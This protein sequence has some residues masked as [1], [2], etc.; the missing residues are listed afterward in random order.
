MD[1]TSH[2]DGPSDDRLN[3][4][5]EIAAYLR[6]SE[7]TVRRWQSEGLPVHRHTHKKRAGIYA[8][9]PELDAWWNGHARL[10]QMDEIRL[11]QRR[12]IQIWIGAGILAL[13]LLAGM[14]AARKHIE[15]RGNPPPGNARIMV[16]VLPFENLGG[17]QKQ[18]YFSDG[19]TEEMIS[20][21]GQVSPQRLGVI[22]RTSAMHY[23][24][25]KQRIDE[26]GKDLGVGYAIEGT[27]RH[28]GDLVRVSAQLIRV[29]D[30]TQVWAKSYDGNL[31]NV[32]QLQEEIAQAIVD[33]VEIT[34]TPEQEAHL[35]AVAPV[36]AAAHEA[37]LKGRWYLAKAG[38]AD[39]LAARDYFTE[40]ATIDPRYAPAFAGLAETYN[41]MNT[42]YLAP[43][44]TEPQ[45][46]AA[47]T[48]ALELDESLA[49]AHVS[50]GKVRL[51]YDWNWPGAEK[52]FL[53]ALDLNPN[54]PQAHLGYAEY[55]TT[56]GQ[57]DEAVQHVRAAYALDPFSTSERIEG[58]RLNLLAA[59]RYYGEALEECRK[60]GELPPNFTEPFGI[61]AFVYARLGRF[62]EATQAGE[63]E[64]HRSDSPVDLALTAQGLAESGKQDEARELLRRLL[65]TAR[66]SFVCG[67]NLA[68]VY[69]ALGQKNEA[70]HWLDE[71]IKQR[72]L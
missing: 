68:A 53:S 12:R 37:Y 54:L 38:G 52:E 65:A 10:E 41:A 42:M 7:R 14:Y 58:I 3:S 51:F 67:Y 4:W 27:V 69:A 71:G 31:G 49:E 17:D 62:G 66:K 33:K 70:F 72:S 43:A 63:K 15:L 47:A 22:A 56:I 20:R 39:L 13:L 46:E 60:V 11:T 8:Y 36:N 59:R 21:L 61:E 18:Q 28:E 16:A 34:L 25:T 57:F 30:Q 35:A 5:K 32:L 9:K 50:L 48:K 55:L 44:K 24:G 6:H 19:L 1:L 45:A 64:M 2:A 29:S 26:I 40:A 23:E